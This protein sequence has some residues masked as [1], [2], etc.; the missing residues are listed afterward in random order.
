[1]EF[2]F[3]RFYRV[4]RKAII[5]VILFVLIYLLRDFFTLIFLTFIL[6]FFAFPASKSLT[7]RLHLPQGISVI[8]V[9]LV[10]F[11]SYI[12][13]YVLV[14]PNVA[15]QAMSMR[16]NIPRIHEKINELRVKYTQQYP[17]AAGLFNFETE[18]PL[19]ERNEVLDW[20]QFLSQLS[21]RQSLSKIW[22][23]LPRELEESVNQ[24]LAT[25]PAFGSSQYDRLPP[26][27]SSSTSKTD[28]IPKSPQGNVSENQVPIELQNKVVTA[29]NTHLIKNREFFRTFF[30]NRL[31]DFKP[32]DEKLDKFPEIRQHLREKSPYE[33]SDRQVQ[34]LN[35]YLLGQNF[36]IL[37]QGYQTER[38][39]NQ[40]IAAGREKLQEYLP[41]IALYLLK[42]LW[43]SLLAILFSF[44]IVFDY[45][46]LSK[47]VKELARS[48]I[49][50]FFAEAG[51]PVI[52]FARSVGEGFEAIVVIA[53]ITAIMIV[54]ML[55]AMEIPS[56]AFLGVLAFV[57]SLVPVVGMFFEFVPVA[58]VALN[59][60]GAERAFWAL[61]GL[62][63]IHLIIGY[64]ITPIIFGRQ[65]KINIVA[66]LFILFIGNQIAGVWGMILGVPVANYLL[67]DVL[68]V[69]LVDEG[70][71]G[72]TEIE[73]GGEAIP[74]KGEK[75]G[76]RGV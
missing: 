35:R 26:D 58:L 18:S 23:Y 53:F 42:F 15:S 75:V 21:S 45:A 71:G 27:G 4:N 65:F 31:E 40:W 52:R 61:L 2:S 19:L 7:K 3:D 62:S 5:W 67:R 25:A 33:L 66:V 54:P 64:V 70:K 37:E 32:F 56:V 59:A 30:L 24:Y 63:V 34:K 68:G 9:Y 13:V 51:Q 48:R 12:A 46:R 28:S 74:D 50:D 47:E 43:N 36:L 16:A 29:I 1:M 76:H 49:S 17:N 41:N 39:I 73:E 55:I 20:P 69:P 22:R 38:K 57:T 11:V 14:L 44:L 60:H 6:S 8:L 10:I 72:E